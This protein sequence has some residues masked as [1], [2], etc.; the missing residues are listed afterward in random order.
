MAEISKGVP[1]FSERAVHLAEL[2]H[3]VQPVLLRDVGC[4]QSLSTLPMGSLQVLE[5]GT[6]LRMFQLVEMVKQSAEV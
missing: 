5:G 6:G 4:K 3:L 2:S 1:K